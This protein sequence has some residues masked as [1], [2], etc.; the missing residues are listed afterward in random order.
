MEH[1]KN[2]EEF[3]A[4]VEQNKRKNKHTHKMHFS[5]EFLQMQQIELYATYYFLFT[6]FTYALQTR[7]NRSY[8]ATE[9]IQR[10]TQ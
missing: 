6:A 9:Y 2:V 1:S 8:L 4:Y 10:T 3:N 7:F 5:K